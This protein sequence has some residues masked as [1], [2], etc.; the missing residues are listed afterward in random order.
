[1]A[2]DVHSITTGRKS[3]GSACACRFEVPFHLWCAK[4]GEKVAKG[5]RFNAE[6][7]QIGGWC[8]GWCGM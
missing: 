5:E 7:K 8:G 2:A 4:C 1:M 3:H 6:K